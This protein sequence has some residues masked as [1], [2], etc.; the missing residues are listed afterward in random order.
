MRCGEH[1]SLKSNLG[2]KEELDRIRGYLTPPPGAACRNEQCPNYR[3]PVLKSPRGYYSHGRT[4][5]G[6]PR[7]KCKECGSTIT[8]S[9][10]RR[11]QL[12]SHENRL[13]IDLLI[14]KAPI[15]AIARV[16]D[17]STETGRRAIPVA[18]ASYLRRILA[19][20]FLVY[21]F[22]CGNGLELMLLDQQLTFTSES[23]VRV[24]LEKQHFVSELY[25]KE[26]GIRG[27]LAQVEMQ[28]TVVLEQLI[29]LTRSR[30]IE[31][32]WNLITGLDP[33]NE[34]EKVG[35][36]RRVERLV[37]AEASRADRPPRPKLLTKLG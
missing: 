15:K 14:N 37:T 36:L 35:F 9:T 17:L 2:I 32:I 28:H 29:R 21:D 30:P 10:G 26:Q 25:Q 34:I 24:G 11:R 8:E 3:R 12:K 5:S 18:R 22:E 13:V 6:S 4:P 7:F 20:L 1:A 23:I 31:A 27:L 16:A 33:S 19:P